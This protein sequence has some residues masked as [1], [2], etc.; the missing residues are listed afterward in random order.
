MKHLLQNYSYILKNRINRTNYKHQRL[1]FVKNRF[2]ERACRY[3]KRVKK[4]NRPCGLRAYK[5]RGRSAVYL[6]SYN[7]RARRDG[8]RNIRQ[9][10]AA[11][12]AKISAL[13]EEKHMEQ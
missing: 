1:A 4:A 11:R 3:Q 8:N 13:D 10:C 6:P 2:R 12:S 5:H 9:K 7:A